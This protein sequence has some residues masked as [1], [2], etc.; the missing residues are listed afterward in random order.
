[1]LFTVFSHDDEL[2]RAS[3]S[4]QCARYKTITCFY[5]W[6]FSFDARKVTLKYARSNTNDLQI[7]L[8]LFYLCLTCSVVLQQLPFP[9]SG[10]FEELV[11]FHAH[12]PSRYS[13]HG[14]SNKA[15]PVP[16]GTSR[17]EWKRMDGQVNEVWEL[18]LDIMDNIRHNYSTRFV[19]LTNNNIVT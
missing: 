8:I 12:L 13:N 16:Q 19:Y 17:I 1:M 9:S 18:D 6:L 15:M 2:W 11:G 4:H 5:C 7:K 10:S 14:K 3:C